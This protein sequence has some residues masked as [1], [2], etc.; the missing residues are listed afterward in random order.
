MFNKL[1]KY[2]QKATLLL[3]SVV[4]SS[5]AFCEIPDGY[6]TSAE[7]KKERELKTALFKIINKHTDVGYDGLYEVYQ[8]ADNKDGEI[9]DMYSTCSFSLGKGDRCGNYKNVCD[10]YNREHTIPQSWF[11]ERR[12][13]KSDAFHVYPTDGKVNGLR[14]NYPHGETNGAAVGGKGLGKLGTC[15]VQGYSGKVYEPDDEYKGDIARTYFYFVT[16]YE[17]Q[18]PSFKGDALAQNTY[19]SLADWFYK[20]MLEWHRQDPVSQKELDRQE[21]VYKFQH[22]RNP[23]IDYP[24]LA[25]HIWGDKKSSVWYPENEPGVGVENITKT[26]CAIIPNPASDYFTINAETSQP[27]SY[28]IYTVTGRKVAEGTTG[29]GSMISTQNIDSGV[30]IVRLMIHNTPISSVKLIIQ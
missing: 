29:S 20:L 8:T 13:M 27:I 28:K 12:P 26:E 9:W 24:E 21:A 18:I 4:F 1:L 11:N 22:N 16:C 17:S 7:G 30:Y 6:Y 19:P 10:C 23:F 3:F 14:S 15:S 2:K 5:L 25:E